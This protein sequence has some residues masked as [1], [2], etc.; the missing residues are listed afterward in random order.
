V[1]VRTREGRAKLVEAAAALFQEGGYPRVSIRDITRAVH[2]PKGTFYNYFE[3]KEQLAS[4]VIE[5]QFAILPAC[6]ADLHSSSFVESVRRHLQ[7]VA[8][9]HRDASVSPLRLIGTLAAEAP[10]LPLALRIQVATGLD[11]WSRQLGEVL[12]MGQGAGEMESSF[13]AHQFAGFLVNS[14]QGAVMRTKCDPSS[15]ALDAFIRY[16]LH[17]LPGAAETGD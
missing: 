9:Q 15:D 2:L 11:A 5:Q 14:L 1:R 4:V 13:D 12:A 7:S 10:A 17:R 6:V 16:G 3:S 8:R